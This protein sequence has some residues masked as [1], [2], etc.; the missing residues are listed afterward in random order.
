MRSESAAWRKE[1]DEA[2]KGFLK[3]WG[4]EMGDLKTKMVAIETITTAHSLDIA[5]VNDLK[6][7]AGW[8][9]ST[10]K[11]IATLSTWIIGVIWFLNICWVYIKDFISTFR[12]G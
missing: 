3:M 1:N 10:A 6:R 2:F 7:K 12:H 9:W 4:E 8:G 11:F 5:Y